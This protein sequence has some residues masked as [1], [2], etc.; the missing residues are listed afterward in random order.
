MP[1]KGLIQK[2]IIPGNEYKM[3][4]DGVEIVCTEVSGFEESLQVTELPDGTAA[5]TGRTEVTEFTAMVPFHHD[6]DIAFMDSWWTACKTPVQAAAYKTVTIVATSSSGGTVRTTTALGTFIKNR[7]S[8]D[9]S[10]ED[11]GTE[12]TSI[13]YT[14]SVDDVEHG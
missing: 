1:L 7:K 2:D 13:E 10:M 9:F 3:I 6:E 12:M 14:F 5:T 11:G 8:P 4:V